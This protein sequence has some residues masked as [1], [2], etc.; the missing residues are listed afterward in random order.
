MRAST[1]RLRAARRVGEGVGAAT[2]QHPVSRPSWS[3]VLVILALVL[4]STGNP[5]FVIPDLPELT[6]LP[7]AL[8]MVVALF[9]R[10]GPAIERRDLVVFAA[11]VALIGVH[12]LTVPGASIMPSIGFLVRL[13]VG[14]MA[15][16]LV[17]DA[18]RVLVRILAAIAA[19]GVGIFLLDQLLFVFGVDLAAMLK[20]VSV[21]YGQS[22]AVH[23]VIHN[24]GGGIDRHRNAGLY[25][26]P[27]AL[28]GYCLLGL[29]LYSAF[30]ARPTRQESWF[31]LSA[32]I[33][34]V[35]TSQ[36][37]TGYLLLPMVLLL[38][39]LRGAGAR[40][41]GVALLAVLVAAPI[42]AGLA[43]LA[44]ELPFMR[45]KIEEQVTAVQM[46]SQEWELTRLGTLI[47]DITD[48]AQRP[49]AGWGANPMIRP[50]QQLL[51]ETVRTTQG[52][53]F[54]NWMVKFGLLGLA[55]FVIRTATGLRRYGN[56]S[57]LQASASVLLLCLLLQ[58][59]AFLNYP[60]FMALMFIRPTRDRRLF[61]VIPIPGTVRGAHGTPA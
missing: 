49:I 48:I 54:A 55:I 31:V 8:A 12:L 23:A 29:V 4:L 30:P 58:G 40:G 52:N 37:T 61:W 19:L 47:N 6:L 41:G 22:G 13:L 10:P 46:E 2:L 51:S 32:L 24:F 33:L 42:L 59:E 50:S 28:S 14:Y 60:L 11:F 20:P 53:G 34:A 36:S 9:L 17:P 7:V 1:G 26:E 15:F 39:V 16:R 3:D 18:P 56:L 27:G 5:A 45:T 35:V 38:N 57:W 25:W 21:T 44:Y 43:K